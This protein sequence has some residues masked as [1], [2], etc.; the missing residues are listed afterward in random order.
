MNAFFSTAEL[1]LFQK[2]ALY[3]FYINK[4]EPILTYSIFEIILFAEKV[5]M[6]ERYAINWIS[7]PWFFDKTSVAIKWVKSEVKKQKEQQI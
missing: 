3:Y 6:W 2:I 5:Y 7:H 4:I 1:V